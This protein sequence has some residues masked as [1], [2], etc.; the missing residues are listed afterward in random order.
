LSFFSTEA[1]SAT[2][3]SKF[4][5]GSG[6]MLIPSTLLGQGGSKTIPLQKKIKTELKQKI[7]VKSQKEQTLFP[8]MRN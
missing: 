5:L 3:L 1:I 8:K 4:Q 2:K 7:S 6:S